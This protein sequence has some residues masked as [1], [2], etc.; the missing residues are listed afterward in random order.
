MV[1]VELT[2]AHGYAKREAAL[3][4][5]ERIGRVPATLRADRAYDTRDLVWDLRPLGVT[6]HISQNEQ[7]RR[8]AIDRRTTQHPVYRRSQR[9]C[10]L[11][12]EV[13]GWI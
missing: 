5:L 12:E 4:M 8:S 13:F 2:Q 9:R 6:P 7:G 11:V 1:N 10:K 3:A